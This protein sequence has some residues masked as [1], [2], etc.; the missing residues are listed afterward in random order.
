MLAASRAYHNQ[1]S[2]L[3]AAWSLLSGV[4]DLAYTVQVTREP[5]GSVRLRAES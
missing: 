4:I 3:L 5:V 2:I 1:S